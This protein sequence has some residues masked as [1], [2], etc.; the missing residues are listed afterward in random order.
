MTFSI[1]AQCLSCQQLQT[2]NTGLLVS[3]PGFKKHYWSNPS[4]QSTKKAD[5]IVI[6]VLQPEM[7]QSCVQGQPAESLPPTPTKP[8]IMI[9]FMLLPVESFCTPT[10]DSSL[11]LRYGEPKQAVEKVNYH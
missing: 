8:D 1:S 10:T 4:D 5:D 2:K 11:R 7:K 9:Y 3:V 6:H